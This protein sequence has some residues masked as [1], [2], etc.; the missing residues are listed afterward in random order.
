MISHG[1]MKIRKTLL[2]GAWEC[3]TSSLNYSLSKHQLHKLI[4][5]MFTCRG[6][7]DCRQHSLKQSLT[8]SARCVHTSCRM[9]SLTKDELAML[10]KVKQVRR[11]KDV[12]STNIPSVRKM[13]ENLTNTARERKVPASRFGRVMSFGGLA[14]GL[15]LGTLSNSAKKAIGKDTSET[16][17]NYGSSLV[18]NDANMTRIVDTLCR[19]R[20]AALKLG[21]M[22]SIQD[23]TVVN[24]ALLALFD[25]VRQSAD[26]M[27]VSQMHDVLIKELGPNWR[28]LVKEFDDTPFAAASI[29][30][31]HRCVLHDGREAAMKIQ[32]PGVASSIDSDINNL[33]SLLKVWDLFP[34]QFFIDQFVAVA[35]RELAW[36][37][38]YIREAAFA[39][40][41][42]EVLGDESIY[43]VP[44]VI[45][46]LSTKHVLTT[47]LIRGIPIDQA[48]NLDQDTRNYVGAAI[49]QL[50][51]REVFEFRCMQ[52]DP[53]YAN[54]FYNEEEN[55]LYLLDFGASRTYPKDFVDLYLEMVKSAAEKDREKVLDMSYK[56][57]FLT[58]F[59]PQVMKE[60]HIDA[61]LTVGEPFSVDGHFD[62]ATQSTT[63][64]VAKHVPVFMKHRLTPPPEE[65]YSLH[66]KLSGAFLMSM[67]LRSTYACKPMFEDAY[68]Q[69]HSGEDKAF[70]ISNFTS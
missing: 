64:Q 5:G 54:F 46:E 61:I 37:C 53:N 45:D 17:I 43:G 24:P 20:G 56:L 69:Y 42:R 21:Q 44:A 15:A 6:T 10:A 35:R 1:T 27:P 30:Q 39:R 19:V 25:R 70:N 66:R 11:K 3:A 7:L 68:K 28:E 55:K 48:K 60:A 14:A 51:L 65:T 13:Q 49:L 38:D 50:V 36:E 57:G 32:Y 18:L 58:G 47:E 34:P 40:K 4:S 16:G 23:D 29:G 33:V 63:R 22:L 67:K 31:V 62:F 8:T 59:E 41:F 52:T 12:K 2:S 26:Y 9:H